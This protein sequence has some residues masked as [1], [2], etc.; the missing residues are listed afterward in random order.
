LEERILI[1]LKKKATLRRIAV[2]LIQ[3][4]RLLVVLKAKGPLRGLVAHGSGTTCHL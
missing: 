4:L 2:R 3:P 1:V